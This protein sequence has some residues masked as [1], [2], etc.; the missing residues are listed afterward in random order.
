MNSERRPTPILDHA[1]S[2]GYDTM[3]V[4]PAVFSAS[5]T[6]LPLS[7]GKLAASLPRGRG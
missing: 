5:Q 7:T 2:V 4:R 6:A 1:L 3:H